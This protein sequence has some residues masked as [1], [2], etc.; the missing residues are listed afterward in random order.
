MPRRRTLTQAQLEGLLALPT[1]E[2]EL[3]RR[4][5]LDGA[6]LAAVERRRGEH[7]QLGYALQLCTFRYPGRLLRPGEV[8]P[9]PA[10]RF[11]AEQI[12][13]GTAALA[14]YATRPQT[15]REQLD[16]L[17]ETFGFRMFAPGDGRELLA[18]LLPVA[19]ATTCT[20]AI[21]E[22]LAGKGLA[23]AEHLVDAGYVVTVD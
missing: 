21:H 10:L 7:N 23:P 20:T 15:R 9:D 2:P 16:R 19:L 12:R 18:W 4:W 5:T 11:V 6:D 13:V 1:A 8:I 17:R 14:A 22:T 3:I